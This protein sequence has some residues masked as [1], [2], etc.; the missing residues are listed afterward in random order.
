MSRV[1]TE[2]PAVFGEGLD[3]GQQRVG[4]E[5]G[6]FVGL[7][8]DDGG[9]GGHEGNGRALSMAEYPP[10]AQKTPANGVNRGRAL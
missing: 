8:V 3:D 1:S 5:G 2:M 7:G 6:G 10:L 9:L 4:G